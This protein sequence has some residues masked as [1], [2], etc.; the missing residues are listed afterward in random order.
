S[1]IRWFVIIKS[2][3]RCCSC[4]SIQTYDM[5]GTAKHGLVKKQHSII[6]TDS[7]PPSPSPYEEPHGVEEGMLNPIRVKPTQRGAKLDPMSRVCYSKVYTVEHNVKVKEFGNVDAG[8]INLF[9]NQFR[10]VWD[11]ME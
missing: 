4:L 6:H 10:Y 1:K 3:N 2:G 8:S 7:I 5:Q 11:R 9:K